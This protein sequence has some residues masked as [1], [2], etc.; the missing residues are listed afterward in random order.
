MQTM[1]YVAYRRTVRA[2]ALRALLGGLYQMRHT[3]CGEPRSLT[4]T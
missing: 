3:P 1:L 2:S 4:S